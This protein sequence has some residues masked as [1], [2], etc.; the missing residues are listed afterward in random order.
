V[1]TGAI[2]A[3]AQNDTRGQTAP[4]DGEAD[5]SERNS[6]ATSEARLE[7]QSERERK[8]RDHRSEEPERGRVSPDDPATL[9]SSSSRRWNLLIRAPILSADLGPLPEP[10]VGAGLGAGI[11][12]ESW[13]FLVAGHLYRGQAVNAMEPGAA[14][15]AG[16]DLER[17]TAHLAICRGWRSVPFEIAPCVGLAIEHA[18]AR[19]FGQ[20][21]SPEEQSALWAAPSLGAD[22]HWYALKWAALFV[23]AR[24]ELE[25]SR[26]RIVIAGLGEVGQLGPVSARF[27][28]G[29]EWIL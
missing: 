18:T 24:A 20:G 22:V 11:G 25:L 19:G 10:S 1:D 2:D 13:R 7:Q 6:A 27:T 4:H 15:A 26:P 29:M 8:D 16:A 12:Y 28:A 5:K 17:I 9:G 3:S 14:F 21:V 23:G